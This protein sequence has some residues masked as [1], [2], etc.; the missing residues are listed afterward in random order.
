MTK[1]WLSDALPHIITVI[2]GGV[3]SF[4]AHP[5]ILPAYIIIVIITMF[6]FWGTICTHC[7]GYGPGRCP[8]SYGKI[9]ARF[10]KKAERPNFNRAF[11]VN[12]WSVALQWFFPFIV[13]ILFLIADFNW[14]LLI[15]LAVFSLVGFVILPIASQKGGGCKECPQR[16]D[17]PWKKG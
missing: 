9:S 15:S 5:L 16:K 3:V 17:C 12:I 14:P 8:S 4:F 7:Y 2:M 11:K 6:W 1:G 13:G 10:F